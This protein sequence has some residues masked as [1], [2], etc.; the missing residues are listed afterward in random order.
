LPRALENK[1]MEFFVGN[2]TK[3]KSRNVLRPYEAIVR[4]ISQRRS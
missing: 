1:E 3:S 4:S 2:Y